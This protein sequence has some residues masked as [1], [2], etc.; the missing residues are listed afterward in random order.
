MRETDSNNDSLS[1]GNTRGVNNGNIVGNNSNNSP[2]MKSVR[3][4]SVQH[5]NDGIINNGVG[6]VNDGINNN[7]SSN[8]SNISNLTPNK[9][10]GLTFLR[11]LVPKALMPKYLDR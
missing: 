6:G 9:S 8:I 7:N 11:N 4:D 10:L 5:Y 2:Q 3:N 1:V